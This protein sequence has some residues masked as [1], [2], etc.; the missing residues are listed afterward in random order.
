VLYIWLA[1]R[2]ARLLKSNLFHV[3]ALPTLSCTSLIRRPMHAKAKRMKFVRRNIC[4]LQVCIRQPCS[5]NLGV[6]AVIRPIVR[7]I[8]VCSAV[9]W[10]N[11]CDA[12]NH[13]SIWKRFTIPGKFSTKS[14]ILDRVFDWLHLALL[15]ASFCKSIIF[16]HFN[17][18]VCHLIKYVSESPRCLKAGSACL[19]N[20]MGLTI[21]LRR[22]GLGSELKYYASII[23]RPL[24]SRALFR[25]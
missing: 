11:I 3:P 12:L 6:A 13:I 8:H 19:H 20:S 16:F 23:Q 15:A 21:R 25:S 1:I 18:K 10:T 9:F 2:G 4:R 7:G 24:H 5:L 14:E 17:G 22:S